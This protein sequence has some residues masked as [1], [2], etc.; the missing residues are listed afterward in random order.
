MVMYLISS[1]REGC[2]YTEENRRK[3]NKSLNE[4]SRLLLVLSKPKETVSKGIRTN[5]LSPFL[6]EL[7]N[8]GLGRT[9]RDQTDKFAD[10][11]IWWLLPQR[12]KNK[13]IY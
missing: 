8:R 10:K 2:I 6:N 4:I 12:I 1:E 11:N 13:E 7:E 9:W 3:I 5:A